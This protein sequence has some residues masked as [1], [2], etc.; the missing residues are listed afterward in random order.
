MDAIGGTMSNVFL[1]QYGLGINKWL[2]EMKAI[3]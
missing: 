1:Q 3:I 2:L